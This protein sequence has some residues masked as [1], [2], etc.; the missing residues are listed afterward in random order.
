MKLKTTLIGLLRNLETDKGSP[1]PDSNTREV[2]S[3]IDGLLRK[4]TP[5]TALYA[6]FHDG[7]V[8]DPLGAGS[9]AFKDDFVGP[10][11]LG[12]VNDETSGS[13]PTSSNNDQHAALAMP[14][15]PIIFHAGAQ[16]NN[17]PHC[18]TLIV[19]FFTFAVARA[20][21][22][23]LQA[24]M[25]GGLAPPVSVEMTLVDTAP[26]NSEGIEVEGIQYQRSYR[27]VPNALGTRIADY[28]EVF[29]LLSAWS[30]IPVHI[31]F[32]RDFFSQAHMPSLVSYLVANHKQLGQQ[33]APTYG[34]LAVRAACPVPGCHLAEKHG[35]RNQY[36]YQTTRPGKVADPKPSEAAAAAI[37]FHCPRHGPHT[38]NTSSADEL[39][40]LE[41]NAP[42]RNLLRSMSHLL[43]TDRHHVRVTGADYAGMYQETFLYRPLAA[44]SAATDHAR[45]RTPHILYAPLVVDWSGA[46]LSKSLYVRDGG[47]AAMRL[48]RSDGL[49]SYVR[50]KEQVGKEGLR[51]LWDEVVR[52]VADPRKLFR[53]WSVEYLQRIAIQG[54]VLG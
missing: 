41:A 11:L 48:F 22:D 1:T 19:F 40:R 26:V 5:G 39:A 54:E 31:S 14:T 46:K 33:L 7:Q 2:L 13:G 16:P 15:R 17:S 45:G 4:L 47:Y 6:A 51:R 42:T 35:R 23:R 27:D 28:Q 44:W 10:I 49:C 36:T 52:W 37:T 43:D 25:S 30:G 50:L 29:A 3:A 18:G 12:L 24:S 32:Q 38:I 8:H 20:V 34:T 9:Y 53:C 21:R